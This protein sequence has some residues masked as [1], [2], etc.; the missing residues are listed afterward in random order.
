MSW[1]KI[2]DGFA[3]HPKVLELSDAA[4]RLH[5]RALCWCAKYETDGGLSKASLRVLGAKPKHLTELTTA[6]LWIDGP[7]GHRIHDYLKYNPSKAQKD[8]EREATRK[9]AERFRN[10]GSNGASNGP[11]NAVTNAVQNSAPV[12]TR[13]VPEE[14]AAAAAIDSDRER[15]LSPDFQLH[16]LAVSELAKALKRPE[17]VITE[18]VREFV[19]YWT[20]G[21]GANKPRA[22]WQAK[23]RDD[24]RRKHDR[25]ELDAIAKR[26][27]ERSIAAKDDTG[28]FGKRSE[29]LT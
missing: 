17:A 18:A 19:A 26:I 13:P 25:G 3:D 23:C 6:G 9:R 10:G 14:K 27:G 29:W 4:F 5:V 24:I 22:H 2:D 15:P 21:G 28:G 12:P 20:I 16:P 11:S 1:L 7:D 8:A